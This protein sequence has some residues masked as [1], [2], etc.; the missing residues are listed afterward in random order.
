MCRCSLQRFVTSCDASL[1][2]EE[3]E[4]C[5][6]HLSYPT[7]C[8]PANCDTPLGKCNP[9][10]RPTPEPE[11]GAD[12]TPSPT[13]SPPTDGLTKLTVTTE[14]VVTAHTLALMRADRPVGAEGVR[15]LV[16]RFDTVK[17]GIVSAEMIKLQTARSLLYRGQF[18]HPN[19]HCSAFFKLYN[20]NIF[21]H[22]SNFKIF[23]LNFCKLIL[24]IL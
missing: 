10:P 23:A 3:G 7:A 2:C 22:L 8:G 1:V 19:M 18:L 6:D 20:M 24:V 12:T 14:F 13:P 16:E 4:T 17:F 9:T 11:P 21:L 15:I 5:V